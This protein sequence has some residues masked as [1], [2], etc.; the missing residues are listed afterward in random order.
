M[1][2]GSEC[3]ESD[4]LS[5]CDSSSESDADHETYNSIYEPYADEPLADEDQAENEEISEEADI[6]GLTP[7]VLE[8]RYEKVISV[9]SW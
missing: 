3:R 9:D 1:S 4:I 6:D 2:S 5:N 8:Q 7:S